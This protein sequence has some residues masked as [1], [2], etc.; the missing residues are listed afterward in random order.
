MTPTEQI[1]THVKAVLPSAATS[2]DKLN[3][4][5]V[6]DIDFDGKHVVVEWVPRHSDNPIGVSLVTDDTGYGEGPDAVF[7]D[8]QGALREVLRLFFDYTPE[9]LEAALRDWVDSSGLP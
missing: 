1:R 8:V 2:L 9:Q 3:A 7:Q 4:A 5:E 6:L